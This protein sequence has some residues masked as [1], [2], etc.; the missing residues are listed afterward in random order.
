SLQALLNSPWIK[1]H[2]RIPYTVAMLI[3]GLLIGLL[4]QLVASAMSGTSG[5]WA[6][7]TFTMANTNPHLI[8]YIFL[9]TLI[10]ESAFKMESHAVFKAFSQILLLAVLGLLLAA[11]LIAGCMYGMV[12]IGQR[13]TVWTFPVCM[14]FGSILSATDPVAVVALLRE[15]GAPKNIVI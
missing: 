15:V 9:P 12:T 1:K 13:V 11:L 14:L 5:D 2:I 10:F 8:M 4:I 6:F 3:S 7:T